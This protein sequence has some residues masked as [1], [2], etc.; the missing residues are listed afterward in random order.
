MKEYEITNVLSKKAKIA[1]VRLILELL[2]Y[3][4][5]SDEP[6]TLWFFKS[7]DY[8][9][10]RGVYAEVS[11]DGK[12]IE[13]LTWVNDDSNSYDRDYQILTVHQLRGR[14]GGNLITSSGTD[15]IPRIV[16]RSRIKAESGAYLACSRFVANIAGRH[17]DL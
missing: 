9:Y 17:S 3:H 14:F 8:K 11:A 2:G 13:V 16:I 10:Y 7:E 15:R 5:V 12:P 4:D 6:S 1:D